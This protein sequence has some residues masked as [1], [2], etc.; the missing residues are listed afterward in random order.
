MQPNSPMASVLAQ[1]SFPSQRPRP[2]TMP[3]QRLSQSNF[4]GVFSFVVPSSIFLLPFPKSPGQ[5]TDTQRP[6]KVTAGFVSQ[7]RE[8]GRCM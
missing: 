4:N 2:S 5:I 1:D 6:V 3:C 8:E 7:G